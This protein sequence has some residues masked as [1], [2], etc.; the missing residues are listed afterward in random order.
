MASNSL[1]EFYELISPHDREETVGNAEPV[2][3]V[4]SKGVKEV[5]EEKGADRVGRREHRSVAYVSAVDVHS[6]YDLH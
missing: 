3:M 4:D 5:A 2:C 6:A 1:A